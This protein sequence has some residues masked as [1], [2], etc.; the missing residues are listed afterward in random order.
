MYA[1]IKKDWPN[2]RNN[3][4]NTYDWMAHWAFAATYLFGGL[5][6]AGYYEGTDHGF[7]A[8]SNLFFRV[9]LLS[10]SLAMHA[11]QQRDFYIRK[12]HLTSKELA[13]IAET[14]QESHRLNPMHKI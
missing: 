5:A 6:V 13:E 1:Q 14:I 4:I 10:A 12:K 3:K 2:I 8:Y 11:G 9:S 7:A